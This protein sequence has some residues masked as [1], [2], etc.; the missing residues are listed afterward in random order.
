MRPGGKLFVSVSPSTER[1]RV[2]SGRFESSNRPAKSSFR[3]SEGFS[4]LTDVD[5]PKIDSLVFSR[6]FSPSQRNT[7]FE[8]SFH[9]LPTNL[10]HW[11]FCF[12]CLRTALE[13]LRQVVSVETRSSGSQK[14]FQSRGPR[15]PGLRGDAITWFGVRI[16]GAKEHHQRKNESGETTLFYYY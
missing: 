14:G 3:N 7:S 16:G 6:V 15:Q 4:F 12:E 5:C 13:A 1:R 8:E 9:L 10:R 2:K 11:I